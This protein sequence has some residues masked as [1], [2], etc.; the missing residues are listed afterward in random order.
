MF[1][2]IY[3]RF[4]ALINRATRATIIALNLKPFHRWRRRFNYFDYIFTT[5]WATLL[6]LH[7]NY[8]IQ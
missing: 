2:P 5:E 8:S 4:F 7:F 3:G 1:P 6:R